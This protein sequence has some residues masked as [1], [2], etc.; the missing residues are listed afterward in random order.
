MTAI[1]M[2]LT[3]ARAGGILAGTHAALLLLALAG[4]GAPESLT[5]AV[6]MIY[7]PVVFLV[8]WSAASPDLQLLGPLAGALLG[9]A[10][11]RPG[12]WPALPFAAYA[13]IH[14]LAVGCFGLVG[15]L[16]GQGSPGQF[17]LAALVWLLA[18]VLHRASLELVILSR[19]RPTTPPGIGTGRPAHTAG[20]APR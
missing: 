12:W 16:I 18:L 5:N 14:V 20:E 8:V 15:L 17:L 4:R 9:L 10:V 1:P 3:P 6:S 2:T 7:A 11:M 13:A 19:R